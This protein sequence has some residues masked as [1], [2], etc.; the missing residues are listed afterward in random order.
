MSD[1]LV[2]LLAFAALAF[3]GYMFAGY[4]GAFIGFLVALLAI[5]AKVVARREQ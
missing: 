1:F 4:I 5:S 3:L 2:D